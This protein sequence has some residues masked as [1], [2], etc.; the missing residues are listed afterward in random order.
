MTDKQI[1]FIRTI[2]KGKKVDEITRIFNEKF[3]ENITVT[4]M[5]HI[6]HKYKIRSG[7]LGIFEKR[8]CSIEIQTNRT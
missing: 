5:K 1:E 8:T 4:Y 3:N 6:K 2:A 7:P